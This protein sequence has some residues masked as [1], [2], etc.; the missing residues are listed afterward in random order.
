MIT[1][2]VVGVGVLDREDVRDSAV[3]QLGA[4]EMAQ[5]LGEPDVLGLTVVNADLVAEDGDDGGHLAQR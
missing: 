1:H 5:S 4:G 2:R 3:G